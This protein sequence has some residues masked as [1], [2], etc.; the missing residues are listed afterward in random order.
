V[1]ELDQLNVSTR[2]FIRDTP[3]LV[4][5][6]SQNDPLLAYLKLNTRINYTGGSLIGE[7]FSYRGMIGGSY[8]KGKEFNISEVQVEQQAQFQMRFFEINVTLSQEDI[9]V[10]NKGP[11]AVF[12]LIKSRMTTAYQT[13]GVQMAIAQYLNGQRAGFTTGFNG[14]A[15]IIN[16]GTTASWD[17][18][19]YAS[20]GGLTRN[21]IEGTS[22]NST[23]TNVNGPILYK[24]LEETY[25]AAEFGNIQPNLGVT[26]VKAYSY[27][28]EKF[29]PQQ[30]FNDTQDPAIGFN[31]LKFNSATLIKSRYCP[32][33]DIATA[34][35]TSNVEAVRYLTESSNG[36]LVA[37]P[38]LAVASS[39]TLFWLN[40]REPFLNFY[41]S[42]SA[43]FG[44]GFSGFKP[45]QGNTKVAGQVLAACQMTG[46][47]RYHQQVY[48]ILG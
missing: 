31:G 39:E 45:A 6:W 24:T 12:P 30:R 25:G 21:A 1:A 46:A 11:L 16:D 14:L 2:R 15:E 41:V 47:P 27:I 29:Q 34:G 13:M 43:K 17:N 8:A 18:N 33:T 37:Y 42:D 28:K 10:L 23:P 40:A 22:M 3:A 35:T 9:E 26:T 36:A 48:G 4:D 5:Y 32:G 7:N 38:T 20:Y 44:F 19:T